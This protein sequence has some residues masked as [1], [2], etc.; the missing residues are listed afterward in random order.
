MSHLEN[1]LEHN[2]NFVINEDFKTFNTSKFP[3]K[4]IVILTCMDT[5]LVEM[6]PQAMNVSHGDAA[7][8]KNAGAVISHPFGSIMRSILVAINSL[9][10]EQVYVVGHHDCGMA[11]LHPDT[12]IEQSGVSQEKIDVLK[13]AGIDLDTW[14]TGF[15]HVEDSVRNSVNIIK[16]HPLLGDHIPV[17]G[18][19]I[20]PETGKLDLVVNGEVAHS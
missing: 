17:H 20:H 4:K 5:R 12:L 3:D 16:N 2:R 6:V 14:L 13:N 18:L 8:V 11:Q 9:G 1:V 15:E 19:V 10:A 7:I